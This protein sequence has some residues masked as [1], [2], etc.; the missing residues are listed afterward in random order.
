MTLLGATSGIV[1]AP[2]TRGGWSHQARRRCAIWIH[3][4][5]GFFSVTA[6]DPR[7]GGE[8]DDAADLLVI[9]ARVR[10]DLERIEQWIGTEILST[11]RADY[12]FRVIATR[13]AWNGYLGHA[14]SEIDYFNFKNA[15]SSR[16]G[17]PRHDV[18]LSVW[19]DLR[20]LQGP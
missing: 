5:D 17:G 8:R 10:E 16:L 14:T 15:V 7:I 1:R 11:P 13:E 20:R 9:R 19:S 4:Q 18:L 12:P 3:T 6:F 2:D